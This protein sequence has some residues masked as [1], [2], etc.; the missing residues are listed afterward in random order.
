MRVKASFALIIAA[1]FVPYPLTLAQNAGSL[2]WWA[3]LAKQKGQTSFEIASFSEE[4][5]GNESVAVAATKYGFIVARPVQQATNT[6]QQ[7]IYTWYKLQVLTTLNKF[8]RCAECAKRAAPPSM[9]LPLQQGEVALQTWGGRALID[10]I[11]LIEAPHTGVPI[12]LGQNYLFVVTEDGDGVL[13]LVSGTTI[14]RLAPDGFLSTDSPRACRLA[15]QIL[16]LGSLPNLERKLH[17]S[18]RLQ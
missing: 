13:R 8:S 7:F 9:L 18:S 2:A 5:S 14:F 3:Q 16:T 15:R 12:S 17:D 1:A 11:T 6:D 4:E 10:G